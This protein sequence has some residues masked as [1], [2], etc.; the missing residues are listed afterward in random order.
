M[1]EVARVGLLLER[2]EV[3]YQSGILMYWPMSYAKFIK[4][5]S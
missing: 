1:E 4:L 5:S 2:K 3:L